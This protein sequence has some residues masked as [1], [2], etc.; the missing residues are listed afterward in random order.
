[1]SRS[2]DEA[3]TLLNAIKAETRPA[4]R[5]LLYAMLQ[6]EAEAW[7]IPCPPLNELTGDQ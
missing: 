7:G 1:M 6:Q 5:N 2:V 3:I 4:A